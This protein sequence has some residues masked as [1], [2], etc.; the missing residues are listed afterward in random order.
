M[1]DRDRLMELLDEFKNT[2]VNL[3][4]ERDKLESEGEELRT[5]RRG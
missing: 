1:T 4:D 3:I 2:I 5:G